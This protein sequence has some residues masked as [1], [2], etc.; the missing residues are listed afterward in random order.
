MRSLE[1]N[2]SFLDTGKSYIAEIY[3][4][5]ATS[6]WKRNPQEIQIFKK[7]VNSKTSLELILAPGGGQA[8]RFTPKL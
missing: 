4:D 3:A 6:D 1:I 8:I 7:V 2:L 5:E